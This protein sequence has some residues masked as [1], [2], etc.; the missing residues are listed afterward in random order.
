MSS[1]T[2]FTYFSIDGR[3]FLPSQGVDLNQTLEPHR[4]GG[5][6]VELANANAFNQQPIQFR[7]YRT[8]ITGTT[9][10]APPIADLWQGKIIRV[11]CLAFLEY[12]GDIAEADLE[13]PAVPGSIMYVGMDD[14]GNPRILNHGDAGV[15]QT[16]MRPILVLI[17]ESVTH[18]ENEWEGTKTW[19]I[20]AR[21]AYGYELAK[22]GHFE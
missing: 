16:F 17:V 5:E 15:L 2:P 3:T 13:R 22:A 19:T 18:S 4:S 9:T 11:H 7:K 14:Q 10:T 6:I 20:E 12:P 1:D 21:E 8:R